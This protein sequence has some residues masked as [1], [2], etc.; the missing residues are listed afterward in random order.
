MIVLL[1]DGSWDIYLPTPAPTGC[2]M[3][4]FEVLTALRRGCTVLEEEQIPRVLEKSQPP[5][6]RTVCCAPREPR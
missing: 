2:G 3:L 5:G 4:W 1:E 6:L